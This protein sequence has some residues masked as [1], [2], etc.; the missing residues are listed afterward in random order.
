MPSGRD[1]DTAG[2]AGGVGNLEKEITRTEIT[3]PDGPVVI[4]KQNCRCRTCDG[5][6]SPSVP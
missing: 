4:D 1:P 3:G 6:F 2:G 5:S